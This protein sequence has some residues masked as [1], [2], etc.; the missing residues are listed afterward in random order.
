MRRKLVVGLVVALAAA[1]AWIALRPS[2][3][4]RLA[5]LV[6]ELRA[7]GEPVTLAEMERPLPPDD[8]NGALDLDAAMAW[9][10]EHEPESGWKPRIAGPW[11]PDVLFPYED[12]AT[13]EQLAAL[14]DFLVF[15]GPLFDH[16]DRGA[17][18]PEIAWPLPARDTVE[19][20]MA[21]VT[22]VPVIQRLQQFL[23]ARAIS[24]ESEPE[25][26]RAIR[27]IL[28]I[29]ARLRTLPLIDHL[30]AATVHAS[31]SGLL[32][33]ALAEERVDPQ[34]ARVSLDGMLSTQ[35]EA[36]FPAVVRGERAHA[37]ETIPFWLDGSVYREMPET[38]GT[39][40]TVNERFI[41]IVRGLVR[42]RWRGG[43]GPVSPALMIDWARDLEPYLDP[44]LTQAG[45]EEV[46]A[47]MPENRFAV[48]L[49][50]LRAKL[51]Q[52]DMSARL[53]RVALA[54]HEHRRV[55]GDWPVETGELEPLFPGGVPVDPY[56]G[57]PFAM[58]RDGDALVLSARPGS[59][60][61]VGLDDP[62]DWGHVWRL[63]V[64]DSGTPAS[65]L[66]T[67]DR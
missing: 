41:R 38:F 39:P 12:N 4:D 5:E 45:T 37:L 52:C 48:L 40:P 55:H 29:G 35:W 63:P 33:D 11:N 10:E 51:V 34:L 66:P 32:R 8:Q 22:I 61:L 23:S 28:A 6:A 50:R 58:K 9:F 24:G 20:V 44:S 53:G 14:D 64:I 67:R 54:A 59:E 21:G 56:T 19:S 31:G 18:K 42:G 60:L 36:R 49:P 47:G 65:P 13:P 3:E 15:L 27:S 7:R 30:V 62:L 43:D 26:R 1:W 25:R 57:G 2:P 16:V 17:D 46:F